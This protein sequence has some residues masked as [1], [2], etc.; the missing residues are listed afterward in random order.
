MP[1]FTFDVPPYDIVENHFNQVRP[2]KPV[3][4]HLPEQVY[5]LQRHNQSSSQ[6]IS[7]RMPNELVERLDRL[8]AEES[9]SRSY[10]L[11]RIT[12]F[13]LNSIRTDHDGLD[14]C[15]AQ[16]KRLYE[17]A[18]PLVYS[19]Q[20]ASISLLQRHLRID[21]HIALL[22]MEELEKNGVVT[23]P[24]AN[25]IRATSLQHMMNKENGIK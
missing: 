21:Y 1:T 3:E 10:V 6:I 16:I 13:V 12:S 25:G 20:G 22:L 15:G 17:Q 2:T 19:E 7:L 4:S 11:R 23:A 24:D 18:K 14:D 8:A 9:A 5:K